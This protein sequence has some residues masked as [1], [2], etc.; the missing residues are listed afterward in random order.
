MSGQRELFEDSLKFAA[1]QLSNKTVAS[2]LVQM[3]RTSAYLENNL[4]SSKLVE[5]LKSKASQVTNEELGW[6]FSALVLM[7]AKS[8]DQKFVRLLE[9]LT[10]RRVH[11]LSAKELTSIFCSYA[12]LCR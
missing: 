11:G 1:S 6:I 8:V 5:Y 9:Y 12:Y 7:D 2:D 4:L 10:M 3:L